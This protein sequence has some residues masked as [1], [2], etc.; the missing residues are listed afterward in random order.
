MIDVG[1]VVNVSGRFASLTNHS[2]VSASYGSPYSTVTLSSNASD[3]GSITV[4][5][6]MPNRL[7]VRLYR[8]AYT[9]PSL[10]DPNNFIGKYIVVKNGDSSI[11]GCYR[12]ITAII[13]N[14]LYQYGVDSD[15]EAG[16]VFTLL[17]HMATTAKGSYAGDIDENT[18][19][20]IYDIL[21]KF[22]MD[23]L[24]CL[25]FFDSITGLA[26]GDKTE[27]YGNQNDE[28]VKLLSYGC[29]VSAENN[30]L[31]VNPRLFSGDV[32]TVNTVHI[33]PTEGVVPLTSVADLSVYGFPANFEKA[34]YSSA[35]VPGLY[36]IYPGTSP[37][38]QKNETGAGNEYDKNST[39][40]YA[41]GVSVNSTQHQYYLAFKV[42]LPGVP[43]NLKF[44]KAY[45]CLKATSSVTKSGGAT[46]STSGF[47]VKH[48]GYAGLPTEVINEDGINYSNSVTVE[49]V[50]DFY[51]TDG[52]S[53]GNKNF[54]VDSVSSSLLSGYKKF[55]L[56][57]S[58]AEEYENIEELVVFFYRYAAGA[59]VAYDLSDTVRFYEA[60]IIFENEVGISNEV[61]V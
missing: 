52:V 41:Y 60:A 5:L 4:S 27:V 31:D 7:K 56:Q 57:V 15:I 44:T 48:R 42:K 17:D 40:Y 16:F 50:P 6:F 18:W 53:T 24:K 55:D 33:E 51:Y 12:K 43:Q 32:S 25:G 9:W 21:M 46:I 38:A 36:A 61:Y 22:K 14:T 8:H 29:E 34:Y 37:V 23:P 35:L 59:G 28:I 30:E 10:V 39:T 13:I 49:N 19:V 54:Y 2:I 20:S 58:G 11:V 47:I 45:L 1:D 26:L 3:S